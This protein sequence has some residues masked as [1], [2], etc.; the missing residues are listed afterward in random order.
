MC[1]TFRLGGERKTSHRSGGLPNGRGEAKVLS[2]EPPLCL[3]NLKHQRNISY[4]YFYNPTI[5]LCSERAG[6]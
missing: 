4:Y 5:A 2:L 6:V 3:L 1:V